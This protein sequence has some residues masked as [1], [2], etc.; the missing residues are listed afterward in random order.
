MTN[1]QIHKLFKQRYN[2]SN[3][4]QFLGEAF[5]NTS[6]LTKPEILPGI[7]S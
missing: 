6:L 2:Q 3:W 5:T 7:D 4:K 1:E